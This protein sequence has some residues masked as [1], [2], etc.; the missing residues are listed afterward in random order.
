MDEDLGKGFGGLES[1]L[2]S[3]AVIAYTCTLVVRDPEQFGR[4]VALSCLIACQLSE[5]NEVTQDTSTA[6]STA[7]SGV[8][9]SKHVANAVGGL[10]HASYARPHACLPLGVC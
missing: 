7:N 4:A 5:Y 10:C 3:V 9:C 2:R 1:F 8:G 6:N